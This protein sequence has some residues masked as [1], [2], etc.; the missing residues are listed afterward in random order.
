MT[1]NPVWVTKSGR[2]VVI[3]PTLDEKEKLDG[4]CRMLWWDEVDKQFCT[5]QIMNR[6]DRKISNHVDK[7]TFVHMMNN[8]R[9]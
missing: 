1:G 7:D 2:I 6:L 9:M 3:I 8:V 4:N 5:G